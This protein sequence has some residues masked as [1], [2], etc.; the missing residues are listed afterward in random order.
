MVNKTIPRSKNIDVNSWI[1]DKWEYRYNVE[2]GNWEIIQ[3]AHQ[4]FNSR[5]AMEHNMELNWL[6][7]DL[8]PNRISKK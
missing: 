6:N 2:W 7:S 4:W 5:Q 8:L 1:N 3:W